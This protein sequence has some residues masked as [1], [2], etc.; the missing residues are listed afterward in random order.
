MTEEFIPVRPATSAYIDWTGTAVAEN[1]MMKDSEDLHELA[2][3]TRGLVN[4]G[5][6]YRCVQPWHRACL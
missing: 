6:R 4:N 5:D 2:G 1:S 3:L